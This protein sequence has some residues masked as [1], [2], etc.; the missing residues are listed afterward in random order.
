LYIQFHHNIF[1]YTCFTV[2]LVSY[3]TRTA[4]SSI[5]TVDTWQTRARTTS[6]VSDKLSIFTAIV[7][8][9]STHPQHSPVLFCMQLVQQLHCSYKH[10]K[11]FVLH[12]YFMYTV[13][14]K[15]TKPGHVELRFFFAMQL[16][17][18][19]CGYSSH[20]NIFYTK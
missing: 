17:R 20:E 3:F 6:L 16:L 5:P 15:I 8:A 7:H 11:L 13:S 14:I 12:V 4:S 10:S 2:Q 1:L 19:F 18:F 9:H